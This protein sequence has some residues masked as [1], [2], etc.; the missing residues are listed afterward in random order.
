MRRLER[1]MFSP[2]SA[3][4]LAALRIGLCSVLAVRLSRGLYLGLA[5]Q[6]HELFRPLSFMQL[7]G[8][9]PSR[10]TTLVVQVIGVPAAVL[11]AF[12]FR[13]RLTLPAAWAAGV[14]LNGMATSVGKVVHND[15]L[16][17]LALI[18][19]LPA[20]TADVWSIDSRRQEGRQAWSARYGWPLRTA[21]VVVTGGYFFTGLAKLL[22]SGLAWVTSDNLRW[23]LYASSDAQASPNGLGLLIADHPWLAHLV[24]A[25]TLMLELGFPLVLFRPRAAWIF[26][27]GVVLLHT[28]IWATMHLDYFAWVATVLVVF[29]DWPA[30]VHR[31]RARPVV[32]PP[33]RTN[34]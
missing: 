8:S 10:T 30:L 7:F 15:V 24:A 26:V 1:W 14:F 3:H 11:A 28:S 31:V 34:L 29:V 5:G 22:F 4:R 32:V 17:L 6:P 9:M 20:P 23:V 18:P 2:G 21:M 13:A 16:L 12:G 25:A 19:L 27:P 33:P